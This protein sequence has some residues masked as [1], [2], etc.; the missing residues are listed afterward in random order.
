M[1]DSQWST[2]RKYA[3]RVKT[4]RPHGA[5]APVKVEKEFISSLQQFPI[6]YL[7]LLPNLTELEWGELSYSALD[8]SGVPLLKYFAGPAVTSVTLSYL[9]WLAYSSPELAIITDLPRLCPNVTSFTVVVGFPWEY[10]PCRELGRMVAQWPRLQTLRTCA[11]PQSMMDQLFARRTLQSLY[12]DYHSSSP[13][14]V[15]RIPDAVCEFTIGVDSASLCTRILETVCASPTRF[16]LLVGMKAGPEEAEI[17][18]LFHLLPFRLDASRLLSLTIQPRSST[19][20]ITMWHTLELREPLA[21]TLANFTAL[22]ELDL[23][24]FCTARMLDEDYAYM[25]GSLVHLRSLKLGTANPS[26]SRPWPVASIGAVIAVLRYCKHLETLHLLFD[27]S[28]PPPGGLTMP[29]G[30]VALSE[31]LVHQGWAWGVSN[32][33]ITKLFVGYSPIGYATIGAVASCFKSIMPRLV[34]IDRKT[35][36]EEWRLVQDILQSY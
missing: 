9:R 1:D 10:Q 31:E 33:C 12:L 25:A 27:A 17:E 6:P 36:D 18:K 26:V 28:I 32:R 23:D 14:Y 24:L 29:D 35:Q 11:L 21:S 4:F 3:R 22:R 15:G 2:F 30:R 7:P 16:H 20:G 5:R 8:D 34:Q 19:M 13:N